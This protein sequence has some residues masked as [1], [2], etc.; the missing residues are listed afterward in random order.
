MVRFE[1]IMPVLFLTIMSGRFTTFVFAQETTVNT[2]TERPSVA[3]NLPGQVVELFKWPDLKTIE[4]RQFKTGAENVHVHRAKRSTLQWV[5]K[6]I[7]K[8]W[9]PTEPNYLSNNLTMIQNEYGPIDATHIEWKKDGYNIRVTQS[10]TVLTITV[11]PDDSNSLG[12]TVAEIKASISQL[13]A[14]IIRDIPKVEATTE[15]NQVINI[16]PEGTRKVLLEKTFNKGSVKECDD[17]LAGFS[18]KL[19]W[20]NNHDR[21]SHN[22]WWRHIDWWTDGSVV[23]LYTLKIEDGPWKASYFPGNDHKW[24]EGSPQRRKKQ[25]R[26]DSMPGQSGKPRYGPPGHKPN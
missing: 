16:V 9:L 3:D 26:P 22:Y 2:N 17:G 24:F 19:D 5:E 10:L 15:D 25:K 4:K 11:I 7:S 20:K 12:N 23:G 6:V 21:Q 1:L 18:A 8:D 13:C 14:R